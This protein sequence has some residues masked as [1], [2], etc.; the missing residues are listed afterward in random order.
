MKCSSTNKSNIKL[1]GIQTA[2]RRTSI[3]KLLLLDTCR[4]AVSRVYNAVA[5]LGFGSALSNSAG[6][7]AVCS[8]F[9]PISSA[10]SLRLF[11]SGLSS[12]TQRESCTCVSDTQMAHYVFIAA[13]KKLAVANYRDW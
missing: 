11:E 12:L 5:S 7:L 2:Q 10:I 1:A 8:R 3:R 4:S 13:T 9:A 6:A